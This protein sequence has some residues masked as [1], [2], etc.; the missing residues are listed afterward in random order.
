MLGHLENG[1]P[2]LS[3]DDSE[4][5]W[6]G[7]F[8]PFDRLGDW[9]VDNPGAATASMAGV[10]A[11]VYLLPAAVLSGSGLVAGSYGAVETGLGV[12]DYVSADTRSEEVA[13]LMRAGQGAALV[14]GAMGGPRAM[15]SLVGRTPELAPVTLRGV[16]PLRLG[17]RTLD[18]MNRVML[19]LGRGADA[20]AF[21]SR[22]LESTP[23]VYRTAYTMPGRGYE[24][25]STSLSMVQRFRETNRPGASILR[26]RPVNDDALALS[27]NSATREGLLVS[28]YRWKLVELGT[29]SGMAPLSAT[30]PVRVRSTGAAALA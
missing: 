27:V 19:G 10:A 4:Y 3:A 30:L 25:A 24:Y 28:G 11:A 13:G 8:E 29:G 17:Q 2:D 5:F 16:A 6:H 22:V 9:A 1:A 23:V 21:A 12:T 15:L 14:P 18:A 26:G 20:Q 7:V